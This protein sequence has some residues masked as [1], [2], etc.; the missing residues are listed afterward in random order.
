MPKI[1]D[2]GTV[3][4]SEA[5][6]NLSATAT[7]FDAAGSAAAVQSNLDDHE[8]DTSNPHST[9]AAQV[10]AVPTSGGTISGDL[11]VSGSARIASVEVNS[12]TGTWYSLVLS[13]AGK[14]I[15]LNNSS[16]ITVT[17]PT[18]A[19]VA[20][21]VGATV[22]LVQLGAGTVTVVGDSG[23]TLLSLDSATDI[24][25]QYGFASLLKIGTNIWALSGAL[26]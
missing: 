10:S 7:G 25:G 23:V 26:A 3:T 21:D 11:T 15:S 16:A 20:F 19:S 24:S 6:G 17:I 12:Q 13:D 18:N 8:A 9:T 1:V 22:S 5:S 2:S 4:W 14:V